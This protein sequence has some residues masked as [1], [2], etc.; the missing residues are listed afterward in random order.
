[1]FEDFESELYDF[2][3]YDSITEWDAI[4][5]EENQIALDNELEEDDAIVPLFSC[6]EAEVSTGHAA[7]CPLD[8][9][10]TI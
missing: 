2:D 9:D 3:P 1:M 8:S 5:F 4:R 6:C 10:E 7:D